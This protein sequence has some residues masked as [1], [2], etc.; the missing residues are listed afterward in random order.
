MLYFL[1]T[2]DYKLLEK[3]VCVCVSMDMPDIEKIFAI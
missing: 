2:T 3:C 1:S